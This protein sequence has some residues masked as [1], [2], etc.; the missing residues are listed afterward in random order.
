MKVMHPRIEGL[1]LPL[2]CR[3]CAALLPEGVVEIHPAYFGV[4]FYVCPACGSEG[5]YSQRDA[6]I[7]GECIWPSAK[8]M[9]ADMEAK[10]T[11]EE[12]A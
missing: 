7:R 6:Y 2:Y 9:F 1:E 11:D 5:S 8:V 10:K 12:P 4:Y 3:S